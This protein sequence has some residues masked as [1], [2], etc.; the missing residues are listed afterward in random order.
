MVAILS[1][2]DKAL[3]IIFYVQREI[4]KPTCEAPS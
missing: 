3:S 4:F 1:K 2:K